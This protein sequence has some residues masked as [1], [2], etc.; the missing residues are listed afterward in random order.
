MNR[1]PV[2]STNKNKESSNNKLQVSILGASGIGKVHARTFQKMGSEVCSILSSSELSGQDTAKELKELFNINAKPFIDLKNLLSTSKPDAVSICT[3]MDMHFDHILQCLDVNIPVFCEK[4]LFWNKGLT[5]EEF[6]EKIKLISDHPNRQ[7][8]MNSSSAAYIDFV[9]E[10]L[11]DL[12][13]IKKFTFQF[14]T[15]G[16]LR[17]KDIAIDLLPHGLSMILKLLGENQIKNFNHNES[18]NSYFCDFIFGKTYIE[19]DFME[20]K[21]IKKKFLF[22][23]NDKKFLRI[24]EGNINSY[25]AYLKNVESEEILEIPDPFELSISRF[26][27]FCKKPI[28]RIDNFNKDAYVMELMADLLL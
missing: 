16:S 7:V 22:T 14:H 24:Q 10:Y 2:I 6:K 19:F 28:N 23:V 15:N 12:S 27:E 21:E 1:N 5:S 26:I 17:N 20:S 9:R 18:T 25:K 13:E 4:P 11:D 3:P 8:F